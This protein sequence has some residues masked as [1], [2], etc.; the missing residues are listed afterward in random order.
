[1][2]DD[3]ATER[4][5]AAWTWRVVNYAGPVD[6]GKAVSWVRCAVEGQ[7]DVEVVLAAELPPGDAPFSLTAQTGSRP[8]YGPYACELGPVKAGNYT[9]AVA[10][11]G[12]PMRLWLD[13]SQAAAASLV[14]A[15]GPVEG[16]LPYSHVL[17]LGQLMTNQANFLALTRY[18]AC[19]GAVVTFDPQQ[20]ML[21]EHVIVVGSPQ[22][23]S[24]AVEDR[25]RAAGVH[26]ERAQGNIAGLLDRAVAEGSPL[27]GDA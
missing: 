5:P 9:L 22:L 10:G 24:E 12:A 19:F 8:D 25:V 17:L 26:V 2:S 15:R 3:T 4:A 27:I 18:V 21:A 6:T 7:T 11:V 1:M 16:E 13:G 23:V 14:P 20:A